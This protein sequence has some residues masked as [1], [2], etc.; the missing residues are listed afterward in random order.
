MMRR[1]SLI[2]AVLFGTF[3]D[4]ACGGS[5]VAN[6][7]DGGSGSGGSAGGGSGSGGTAGVA[8]TGGTTGPSPPS[9]AALA[10]TCGPNGNEDCC[11]SPL[12]PGGTFHRSYDGA[13]YTDQSYPATLSDFRLDTY[14]I[15]VGR[16]RKFL[17]A[18][19][20]NMIPAGAGRNPSNASD[21]GWDTAWN[22]I[23]P[24]D[25]SALTTAV[26][27]VA[28]YQ[29]WTDSEGPNESRPMNC[30][31]WYAAFAFCIW[32]GGRLP[33]EAEWNYAAAGGIEQRPYPWG[34]A[35]PDCSY[36][37]FGGTNWPATA[38]VPAGTN[39][40]GAESPK[41]D[42]KWGQADLAGNVWEWT[43]DWYAGPYGQAKCMN[44]ANLTVNSIGNRVLRGCD[45]SRGAPFLLA[46]YRSA[47][48]PIN[49]Y[50]YLGGRCAR[51]P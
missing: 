39:S 49:R 9:C 43:Q 30:I 5:V 28:T 33:T 12:V 15:T 34:A 27:C 7:T 48:D 36:A 21:P 41:G 44:C 13:T 26:K 20:Q 32:D 6:G 11:A 3:V 14:E 46:S 45:F 37:N 17:S 47:R 16:F 8:S 31:S 2:G 38:C 40:V 19:S 4:S 24:A 18:Y 10:T 50:S 23:L 22:K 1:S 25:A 42:G 35:G 51:T 29:T